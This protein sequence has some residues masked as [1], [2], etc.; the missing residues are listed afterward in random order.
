[1]AL[2]YSWGSNLNSGIHLMRGGGFNLGVEISIRVFNDVITRGLFVLM[3]PR[4]Y[5]SEL[6]KFNFNLVYFIAAC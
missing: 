6:I 4:V 5:T 2:N 3:A 1:M